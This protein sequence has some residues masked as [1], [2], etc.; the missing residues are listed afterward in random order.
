MCAAMAAKR[1][2]ICFRPVS[3]R[4]I[5]ARQRTIIKVLA[6]DV[7]NFG[8]MLSRKLY[9]FKIANIG[10]CRI[11]RRATSKTGKRMSE[12]IKS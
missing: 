6:A 2:S 11:A 9:E 1:G 12:K 5:F 4:I 8:R 3:W 7:F 10:S